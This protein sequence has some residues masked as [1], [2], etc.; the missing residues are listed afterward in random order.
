MHPHTTHLT[1]TTDSQ[2]RPSSI[3]DSEK[4]ATHSAQPSLLDTKGAVETVMPPTAAAANV[5]APVPGLEEKQAPVDEYYTMQD[6]SSKRES[7][8]SAA[9]EEDDFE[10]PTKWKLA[11]ITVALCLSV[12]CMALVSDTDYCGCSTSLSATV[13][14]YGTRLIF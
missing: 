4:T 14:E 8:S 5:A 6:S 13:G 10:Y 9:D 11:V 12:F 1:D 3:A 2:L 7:T